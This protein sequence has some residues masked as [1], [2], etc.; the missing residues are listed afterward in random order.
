VPAEALANLVRHGVRVVD[1]Q[2]AGAK[3]KALI[4][5][6]QWDHLGKEILHVDFA[7]VSEEE[8]IEV[9]VRLDVRGTAPGIAAGG[10][11]DQPIHTLRIECLAIRIPES[12]RVAVG[13][14]QIGQAIHVKDLKLP[15]GVVALGDADAIVVQLTQRE[16]EEAAA[17][18]IEGVAEPEVIGRKATEDEAAEE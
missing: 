17:A 10:I 12:I 3:D 7:R 13:E 11:L 8:R 5:E 6:L 15:E 9:E 2:L 1:L 14:L 16:D 4:R 18:P